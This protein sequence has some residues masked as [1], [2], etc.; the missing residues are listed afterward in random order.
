MV[1]FVPQGFDAP[2]L[3]TLLG[4][5]FF[6][7]SPLF[8][9]FWFLGQ[10]SNFDGGEECKHAST[11]GTITTISRFDHIV[12]L[13]NVCSSHYPDSTLLDSYDNH[14]TYILFTYSISQQDLAYTCSDRA[15]LSDPRSP[16]RLQIKL[17]LASRMK[18]R[19]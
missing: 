13:Y 12:T 16:L 3:C 15:S 6:L 9:F 18:V 19:Q 1:A 10:I 8:L 2:A 17:L 11:F 14:P 5:I 4:T 7:T